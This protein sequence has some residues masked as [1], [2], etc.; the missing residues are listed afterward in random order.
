MTIRTLLLAGAVAIVGLAGLA[1][2][3]RIGTGTWPDSD[4][5]T[6]L[7]NAQS[8]VQQ[9]PASTGTARK[10]LYYRNPMGLADTSP[11]PKKDWMGMDYIAVYE[12]EE[13][14]DGKTVKVSL[15]KV[16][17]AGV[18]SVVVEPRVLAR[19]IRAAGVV[20]VDERSLRMVTLRADGFIEKLF[21]NSTGQTVKAG[22][23]LFR[24]YSREIV[25]A[26]SDYRVAMAGSGK[27]RG[28]G[29]DGA[30]QKLVNLGFPLKQAMA[31]AD[32]ASLST[33]LDWPSPIDGTIMEKMVIEGERAE[34]GRALFKI[35]DLSHVWVMADLAEQ[36]LGLVR[37]GAK[38]TV[39]LTAMPGETITGTVS[40][41]Y[42]GLNK[43][44][45]TGRIRIELP[46]PDG[47]FK[48]DMYAEVV[49]DAAAGGI[50]V[51]AVP[52]D[53]VID[54]GSSLIVFI[55]KGEGRFEPREVTLGMRGDGYVEV[56]EGA[57]E[58]EKVL[59][60][61]NFLIDAESNLKAALKTFSAVPQASTA[62][63][64]APGTAAA[65]EVQP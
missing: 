57:T 30:L 19:P 35:A 63:E 17:R 40:F 12:G 54:N 24:F 20:A 18:R 37:T 7:A 51:L 55:D 14:D 41:V 38:A 2:G 49:I 4:H 61:A 52:S 43:E 56:R 28:P 62:G 45:R 46:N 64:S 48:P 11:V 36:D 5:V 21:A 32:D 59:T 3:Y 44:T 53:S 9:A 25:A 50:A 58:G 42:P 29:V 15:D 47:R 26:L 65:A 33:T 22:E 10:V 8:Q 1:S 27:K 16:Q 23:P 6:A 39:T 60:A 31:M 34:A 13:V